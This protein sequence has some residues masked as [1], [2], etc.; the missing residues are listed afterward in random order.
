MARAP[1]LVLLAA[2]IGSRYGR[3]K[4]L[5]GFGPHGETLMDYSLYDAVR[6]GFAKVVFVVRREIEAQVRAIFAPRL[7]GRM[8]VDCALQ[9]PSSFLP[10]GVP[11]QARRKP[12][13]T[14]H[15]TLCARERVTGP[16][17]VLNADD[18]YGRDALHALGAFLG[19]GA[20]PREHA[21]VAYRLGNTL[22]DF[23]SVSRG[24]CAR[25]PDGYLA[26]IGEHTGIRRRDGTVVADD[27]LALVEDALVSM[28][29]W[30]FQTSFFDFLERRFQAFARDA[31]AD[32]AAGR[33][34]YLTEAINDLIRSGAG[35]VRL[36]DSAAIWFGVT[37]QEDRPRVEREIS[38]LV[39]A[40]EYPED[41]WSQPAR[42]AGVS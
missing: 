12:W 19:G 37:Y 24:L 17:A 23:G 38:R 4:Q 9:E 22:S 28:N 18:F 20:G 31:A 1:T 25:A 40:G 2:G 30:G 27:G 29:C 13:G 34:F 41:L 33:E 8:E 16:F 11:A 35:R 36:L 7:A 32:P 15:A 14:G 39:A 10:E 3:D 21:M 26:A 5:D 42:R 6:A